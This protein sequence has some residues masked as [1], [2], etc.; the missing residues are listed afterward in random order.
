MEAGAGGAVTKAK[1]VSGATDRA[2]D[3]AALAKA[4]AAY[5]EFFTLWKDADPDIAVLQQARAEFA[6]L[7]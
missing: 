3:P 7:Q 5:R 4:R 1:P 2:T 6:K